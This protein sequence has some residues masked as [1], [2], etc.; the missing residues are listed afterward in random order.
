[1]EVGV[2]YFSEVFIFSNDMIV[3]PSFAKIRDLKLRNETS[4]DTQMT[5]GWS[6]RL[7]HILD[8]NNDAPKGTGA[9]YSMITFGLQH[10]F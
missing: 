2:T 10:E 3:F 6:L 1:L 9:S 4:L 5:E 8:Y 7:S